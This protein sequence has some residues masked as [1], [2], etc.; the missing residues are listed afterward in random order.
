M[1]ITRI[2][3]RILDFLFPLNNHSLQAL[4]SRA[5]MLHGRRPA[6]AL[7]QKN[8]QNLSTTSHLAFVR[9]ATRTPSLLSAALLASVG[10]ALSTL[11]TPGGAQTVAASDPATPLPAVTVTAAADP[12]TQSNSVSAGALGTRKQ[13]DTPF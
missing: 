4:A 11:S 3:I 13:V 6:P 9:G 12:A 2:I 7:D 10:L 5:V 8:M 1:R